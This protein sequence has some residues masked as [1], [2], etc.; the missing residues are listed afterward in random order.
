MSE[1]KRQNKI[2]QLYRERLILDEWIARLHKS[3]KASCINLV[4]SYPN[5]SSWSGFNYTKKQ[6]NLKYKSN[7]ILFFRLVLKS[8]IKQVYVFLTSKK[9]RA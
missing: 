2:K 1:L 9:G 8:P 5:L 6:D 3:P 7:H 4:S